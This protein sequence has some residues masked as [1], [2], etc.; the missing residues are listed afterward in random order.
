MAQSPELLIYVARQTSMTSTLFSTDFTNPTAI[1]AR[2][3]TQLATE[4]SV[5]PRQI[6]ATMGLLDE[7]ST[8]P[9]IARYRK[10]TTGRLDDT[11]LRNLETRLDY[12]SSFEERRTAVIVSIEQFGHMTD[13]LA[14][15][16]RKADSKQRLE[17]LYAPY[18]PKRRTRAQIAREAGLEPLADAILHDL[19]AEPEIF[20][21]QYINAEANVLDAKSA[22]D[23]ARDILAERFAETADVI[24]DLR[25]FVWQH[26]FLHARVVEGKETEGANFRDWFNFSEPLRKVPSH[27]M[28]AMLRGRQQGVLDLRIG[29]S[30]EEDA[31]VPH[32]CVARLA[33]RLSIPNDTFTP[34][35]SARSRWLGDV[36]RWTWRVK[37]LTA[38]ETEFISNLRESAET[39]AI[40]VFGANLKDLLLAAPAGPKAVLGLDPGIRTG[41]KLAAIDVTGKVLETATIYPFEPRKDVAGSLSTLARIART[42]HIELVAIGNGTAS[43]E[44]EKLVAHLS[45]NN[46]D[47]NLTR[48]VV[49]EAGA[50]IYSASELAAKEFP[51]LDVTLRGAVS[52]ARRLQDPLAELVKIE[53]KAIG[54]GQ[55]QHDVNQRQLMG[56]LDTVVE[57]CVNAVGVD[58]N[59]ASA[60]L[61]MH[62]SGLNSTLAQNIVTH[63]ENNGAFK[64][65]KAL[66]DVTRFGDKAF[67]QAAGF[68][69]VIGGDNPLDASAV[70]PEAYSV[71]KKIL[72]HLKLDIQQT[73]GHKSHL[74]ALSP[75]LFTDDKFGIPTVQDILSELEK[76]GRDPRPAFETAR[77]E[78]G[79]ESMNDL[80]VGM[81]L[82]G[83]VTNVA[84]FGAFVDIGVHQDGLVHISALSTQFVQDPRDV[85]RVGQTV[86]VKVMEVDVARKRIAL[87]MRL[88]D[89][90]LNA[91]GSQAHSSDGHDA[92]AGQ[93]SNKKLSNQGK[94]GTKGTAQ[95][96]TES[97]MARAFSQLKR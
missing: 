57:D 56:A 68:L 12:L 69:K 26:G 62:V 58:V 48:I 75:S 38:F 63:R 66:L 29:L 65:R 85:V 71:V 59:T 88:D 60:A 22:L 40:R 8:V 80:K 84:N 21:L 53:P 49:S 11:V 91:R 93:R 87:T 6:E 79:I 64:N 33:V 16:L 35:A 61:L 25:Q 43:R 9:F 94:A 51:D 7:G 19:K 17:D 27:R 1:R 82:E 45:T 34:Q 67:E 37:M 32:P 2:I 24:A 50:S 36:S 31:L 95:P 81:T 78:D 73:I 92:K 20:A 18:K 70:H 14:T 39:E 77:F 42:H 54:V 4:L 44:T 83:V 47:L 10:E 23:G 96:S 97:A 15:S 3:V 90:A 72:G 52:I 89:D 55:Y 30:V 86:K 28:L 74:Q 13:A 76:P 41:V 46:P 5:A